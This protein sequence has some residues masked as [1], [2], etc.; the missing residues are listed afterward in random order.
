MTGFS[1]LSQAG[2][3]VLNYGPPEMALRA[4]ASIVEHVGQ[5]HLVLVDNFSSEENRETAEREISR[6]DGNCMFLPLPENCGYAAGMNAGMV[7]LF[8]RAEISLAFAVNSDVMVWG[9]ELKIPDPGDEF[10]VAVTVIE[11]GR[12]RVGAS[13][14][15]PWFCRRRP[16]ESAKD[17]DGTNCVYVEGCFVGLSRPLFEATKGF[18]EDYFLYFEELD[19]VYKYRR[20]RGFFPRVTYAPAIIA[21]H[22]HGG[23]TGMRKGVARSAFAEYWSSRSRIAFMRRHVPWFLCSALAYNVL[24]ALRGLL[25]GLR[26]DLATAVWKG[27]RDA[28]CAT[29]WVPQS[30][31][32]RS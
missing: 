20:L 4:C 15:L 22:M 14:F 5:P 9:F 28:L 3:V 21:E 27:T 1:Q 24:L 10:L 16:I 2:F 26:P 32:T 12:R 17:M 11:D 19:L 23:A 31:R 29:G 25:L 6:L 8:E 30:W 13:S 18:S 7:R